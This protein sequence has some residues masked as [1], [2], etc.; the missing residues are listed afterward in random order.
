M[1]YS[2]ITFYF[3]ED[4]FNTYEVKINGNSYSINCDNPSIK[5]KVDGNCNISISH[6]DTPLKL[7]NTFLLF[8][9]EFVKLL[10]FV[11]FYITPNS[12]WYFGAHVYNFDYIYEILD[13]GMENYRFKIDN[14]F[15]HTEINC[16]ER[17][18]IIPLENL[19]V[20]T[21]KENAF[22]CYYN[23]ERHLIKHISK[24]VWLYLILFSLILL[25][26]SKSVAIL[27]VLSVILTILVVSL[28]FLSIKKYKAILKTTKDGS[29]C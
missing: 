11:F 10:F 4:D 25:F 26:F 3:N 16:S 5:T 17:P 20:K 1:E 29:L 28:V 2:T 18:K 19:D 7:G 15:L 27:T 22:V 24:L 23:L 21:I 6:K 12:K 8:L 9:L 14:V 13:V